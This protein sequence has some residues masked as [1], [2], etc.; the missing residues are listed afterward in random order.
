MNDL[1]VAYFVHRANRDGSQKSIC[2][3]C[4]L[5]VATAFSEID[6]EKTEKYHECAGSFEPENVQ[7]FRQ[8]VSRF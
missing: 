5:T 8:A 3:R 7:E 1:S 4:F 6:L 2:L